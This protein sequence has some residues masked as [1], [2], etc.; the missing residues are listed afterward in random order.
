MDDGFGDGLAE[1]EGVEVDDAVDI[2]LGYAQFCAD[3][4]GGGLGDV[5]VQF[6]GGMQGGQE[7]GAAL[8]RQFVQRGVQR[9][10]VNF[11]HRASCLGPVA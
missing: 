9:G 4:D 11:G 7:R 2:G 8:G 3:L 5:A 10:Q 1:E 6:L